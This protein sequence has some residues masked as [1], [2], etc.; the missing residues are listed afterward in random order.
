MAIGLA[1]H[2]WRVLLGGADCFVQVHRPL[3]G[4][5][6]AEYQ[7]LLGARAGDRQLQSIAG[8]TFRYT[9]SQSASNPHITVWVM[10]LYA[11]LLSAGDA[12]GFI[13]VMTGPS[14]IPVRADLETRW[15]NGTRLHV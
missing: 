13:G 2:H 5:T 15:R 12:E 7:K 11:G 1:W 6:R 4:R 9:G 8:D 3:V 10:Q 14:D